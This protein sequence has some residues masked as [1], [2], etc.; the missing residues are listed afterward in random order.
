M[1]RR[2]RWHVAEYNR[3]K[4]SLDLFTGPDMERMASEALLMHKTALIELYALSGLEEP[5]W[6]GERDITEQFL[7]W[8]EDAQ[9]TTEDRTTEENES[10]GKRESS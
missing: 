1:K 5:D 9:T 2:R 6:G 3:I 7:E 8:E 4:A 10:V